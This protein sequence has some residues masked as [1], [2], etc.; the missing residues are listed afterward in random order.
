VQVVITA[1]NAVAELA[2]KRS[3][4]D[5]KPATVPLT[6]AREP[7]P[8]PAGPWPAG[9]QNAG[10]DPTADFPWVFDSQAGPARLVAGGLPRI[11]PRPT[12]SM[13]ENR[14]S[15]NTNQLPAA[16]P[17]AEARPQRSAAPVSTAKGMTS[18]TRKEPVRSL[19]RDVIETLLKQGEDFVS[20]GDFSSARIAFKRVAE[21]GDAR[22]ALA[23]A[24]TYDPIVLARTGANGAIPDV[25]KAREQYVKARDLGS[26]DAALRLEALASR[27]AAGVGSRESAIPGAVLASA[28]KEALDEAAAQNSPSSKAPAPGG[29]YWKSDGSIMRLE[30][31]GI[32]RKFFFYK[33]SDVE[34]NAGAKTG[35][36]RF[37]GQISGK[38]YT[39]TAFLY[40]DK[41]GRSAFRVSGEIENSDS[42]VILSG[43]PPHLDNDCRKIGR[44]DQTLIFD[45][46][47]A[48]PI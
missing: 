6:T 44:T 15:A 5:P 22:G 16:P 7:R 12:S 37:D 23:L 43:R 19:A 38:G 36:L 29:T 31:T 26:P 4:I 10:R 21:A 9:Q 40:S 17:A 32:K 20:V 14:V 33:P 30:A 42:R 1:P 18:P 47:D 28:G 3:G 8:A 41:C 24:A 11:Y 45:F 34:L 2:P 39:G 46:M 25:G 48:P 13:H 27:S 35:S